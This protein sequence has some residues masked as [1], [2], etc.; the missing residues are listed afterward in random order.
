L[1]ALRHHTGIAIFN[2][3]HYYRRYRYEL[4]HCGYDIYDDA[5]ASPKG[6][7]DYRRLRPF[8]ALFH[9]TLLLIINASRVVKCFFDVGTDQSLSF[10][11]H[12]S[13]GISLDRL[14][15]NHDL[16]M[17]FNLIPYLKNQ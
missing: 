6:T 2:T 7:L 16:F 15:Q 17:H 9:L 14:K 1:L 12:N 8:A 10:I 13:R 4:Q 11:I 3:V 5:S